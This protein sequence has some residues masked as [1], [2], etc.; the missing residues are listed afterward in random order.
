MRLEGSQ[1]RRWDLHVHTPDTILNDQYGNWEEFLDE[2]A[3]HPEV[4]ALGIT[5]Y[6]SI[7]NY[8]RV[9]TLQSTD[10]RLKHVELLI[11]NVEFRI[12]PPT[13]KATAINLHLLIS[14]DDP[15]H[16]QET[17]NAMARLHWKFDGRRYS[18]VPGQLA[19]LGKAFDKV[20][21]S[22]RAALRTGVSQFKVDFETF[23]DWYAPIDR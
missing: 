18:C 16:E 13:E 17:L 10:P 22:D 21:T 2:I 9:R 19:A 23:R 3:G 5:D 1:W 8:S 11:P 14:P 15:A 20:I 12:A 6:L 7:E 4:R